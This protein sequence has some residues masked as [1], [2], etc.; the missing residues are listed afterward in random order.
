MAVKVLPEPVA[1]WISARGLF[2]AML[3]SR[4]RIAVICAG[5]SLKSPHSVT[6]SGIC[7]SR[8]RN[9]ASRPCAVGATASPVLTTVAGCSS[10]VASVS[11]LKNANSGRDR[12]SGSSRLVNRVSTPVDSNRNGSGRRHAGKAAGNPCE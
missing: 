12:G 8:E 7:R 2:C 5:Q 3:A 4:L 1:I 10:H 11:G 6:S 9:V